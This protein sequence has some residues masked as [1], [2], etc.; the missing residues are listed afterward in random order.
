MSNLAQTAAMGNAN[1]GT[2]FQPNRRGAGTSLAPLRDRAKV[3]RIGPIRVCSFL[4]LASCGAFCQSESSSADLPPR[5][6][7]NLPELQQQMT[8][9]ESLPDA[10][11]VQLP[12]HAERFHRFGE[13]ANS[14][15][16]PGARLGPVATGLQ[17]SFATPYQPAFAQKESSTFVSSNPDPSLL[18]RTRLYHASTSNSFMGRATYAASRILFTRD[19]SGKKRLNTSYFLQALTSVASSTASRPYWTRSASSTFNNFGSTIGSDAGLNVYR[20]FGPGIRQIVKN[21]TPKFVSG[22]GNR[23]THSHPSSKVVSSPAR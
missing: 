9:M 22:I 10:P 13:Q 11:S 5:N 6:G 4:L 18:R 12:A 8:S 21:H 15:M 23:I 14:L 16:K 3:T 2:F 20:E 19:D 7:S 17:P 1:V